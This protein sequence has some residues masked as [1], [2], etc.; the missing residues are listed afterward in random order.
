[1]SLQLTII[2]IGRLLQSI[3]D[4][5]YKSRFG[6]FK[7]N[8]TLCSCIWDIRKYSYQSIL[9]SDVCSVLADAGFL[10]GVHPRDLNGKGGPAWKG[11]GSFDLMLKSL[12]GLSRGGRPHGHPT[13]P[14]HYSRQFL[15]SLGPQG[16]RTSPPMCMSKWP[17]LIKYSKH[18]VITLMYTCTHNHARLDF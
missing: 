3:K 17:P 5:R 10:E 9:F 16:T 1:M 2:L 8:I 7:T 6:G 18:A 12:H 14:I 15:Y 11:G 13:F 4:T